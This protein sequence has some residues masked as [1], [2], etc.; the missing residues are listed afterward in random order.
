VR[1]GRVCGVGAAL[2][3]KII[4]A[5][6]AP[7]CVSEYKEED[8]SNWPCCIAKSSTYLQERKLHSQHY[9]LILYSHGE[10]QERKRVY[11]IQP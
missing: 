1:A 8:K 7:P 10:Q 5:G 2:R 3:M 9:I 6:C 4:S 11:F